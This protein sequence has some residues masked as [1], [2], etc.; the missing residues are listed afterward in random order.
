MAHHEDERVRSEDRGMNI[1]LVRQLQDKVSKL[2]MENACLTYE[3]ARLRCENADHLSSL[4]AL[5][6]RE[7]Q[8]NGSSLSSVG[9][10]G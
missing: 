3:V 7:R 2:E 6:E 1:A 8:R 4:T 9:A 5:I 10:D